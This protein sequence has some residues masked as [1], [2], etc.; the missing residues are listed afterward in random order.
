[1]SSVAYPARRPVPGWWQTAWDL[2][3]GWLLAAACLVGLYGAG[4]LFGLMG[5]NSS[6]HPP[7]GALNEWPFPDNGWWSLAANAATILL[8]LVLVTV[9]TAWRLRGSFDAVAEDRLAVLLLFTGGVP[10]VV[11][12]RP[13][14]LA[15]F[16]VAVWLVRRWVVRASFRA[17]RRVLLGASVFLMLTVAS[18]GLLHPVWVES[19]VV[20]PS[21][22]STNG[23]V[24][25]VSLHNV[26]R[27]PLTIERVSG[28][29]LFSGA[30][31]GWPWQSRPVEGLR[32]GPGA[33]QTFTLKMASGGCATVVPDAAIHYRVFGF[34]LAAPLWI[35]LSGLPRC[36]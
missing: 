12:W 36:T 16:M 8:A 31:A 32:V 9:T 30:V 4:W 24:L 25:V 1:M 23:R 2:V 29:A 34:T 11:P 22:A 13:G 6:G 35:A 10:L 19:A 17:S 20:M 14:L 7:R 18:Y 33:T 21:P 28:G 5:A 26:S 3:S 27:L 15:G